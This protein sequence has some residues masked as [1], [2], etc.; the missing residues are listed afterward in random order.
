M[1]ARACHGHM[2]RMVDND[3]QPIDYEACT[4]C[5]GIF[6]DAGEFR[7][8]KDFTMSEYLQGLFAHHNKG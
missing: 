5:Y 3:Q 6:L 8:L 1:S 2:I 7:V 4:T